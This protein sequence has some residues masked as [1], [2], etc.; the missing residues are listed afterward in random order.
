MLPSQRHEKANKKGRVRYI[1]HQIDGLK[2]FFTKLRN[3][4]RL[5][6]NAEENHNF[7]SVVISQCVV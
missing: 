4:V 1:M 2:C 5:S 3:I 6:N 7:F